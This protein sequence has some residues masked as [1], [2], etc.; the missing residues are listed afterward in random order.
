MIQFEYTIRDPLGIHARP[1]GLFAKAAKEFTSTITVTRGD[2]STNA[3]KLMAIMSMGIKQGDTITLS[4]EGDD[5][6]Q[7]EVA[8]KQFLTEN[9]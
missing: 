2:K 1:A 5:E 7:A 6:A 3:T 9:L 4:I 8:I